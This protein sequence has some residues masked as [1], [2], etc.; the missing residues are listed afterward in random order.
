MTE[1]LPHRFNSF[2]LQ[3]SDVSSHVQVVDNKLKEVAV[4]L[5]GKFLSHINVGISFRIV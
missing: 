1:R 3:V 4:H 5:Q 2:Y